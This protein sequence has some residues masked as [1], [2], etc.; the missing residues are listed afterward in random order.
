MKI[1]QAFGKAVRTVSAQKGG[2][3]KLLA[4]EGATTLMCLAPLLFLAQQGPLKYLAA[5]SPVLWLLVKVP[6]RMNAAAVM[7]EA[8]EGGSIF[9]LRFADPGLYRKKVLYGLTRLGLLAIWSVPLIA[10]LIY[11]WM[12]YAVT[13]DGLVVLNMVYEFGGN[14]MKT[15]AIY[16]LLIYAAMVLLVLLGAGFH[17]GDQHAL[18]LE[19]KGLLKGKRLKILWFRICSLVFLLPMIGAAIITVLRYVPLLNDL[20]GVMTGDVPKPSTQTSLVILGI[21]AVLTVPFLPMRSMA[22]AVYVNGLKA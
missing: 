17:S 12:Q 1:T 20:S 2:A 10:G 5:L 19:R 8:A 3:L 16:V 18:V 13:S 4:A 11:A 6:A 7:Q 21:G 14:D 9:S 22:T 15:G